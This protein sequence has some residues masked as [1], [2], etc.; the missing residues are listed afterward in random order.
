MEV[1]IGLCSVAGFN[2]IIV[3][4]QGLVSNIQVLT[5]YLLKKVKWF[6]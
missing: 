6:T 5:F 1:K 4:M 2:F 3:I